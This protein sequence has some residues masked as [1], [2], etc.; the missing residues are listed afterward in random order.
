M[1]HYEL[2]KLKR[3]PSQLAHYNQHKYVRE[4]AAISSVLVAEFH[5]KLNSLKDKAF[6]L[7]GNDR[8]CD[9]FTVTPTPRG[10]LFFFRR[11]S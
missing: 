8:L 1:Y 6:D 5:A 3:I 9:F 4:L 10:L 2:F 11:H 7:Q